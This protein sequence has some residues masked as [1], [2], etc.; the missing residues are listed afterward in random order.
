V[1]VRIGED[2]PY[3]QYP[4][5]VDRV[6]DGDTYVVII[7][8]GF[9]SMHKERLRHAHIDTWEVR[10]RNKIKGLKVS[11]EVRAWVWLKATLPEADPDWPFTV[12]TYKNDAQG[13][14]GRYL[15]ELVS[16][17]GDLLGPYLDSVGGRKIKWFG[18]T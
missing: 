11:D 3:R 1:T 15:G 13:K 6:I 14:Y 8:T 18:L 9:H 10:G 7:D 2:T 5:T 12:R 4:C 16:V 17:D